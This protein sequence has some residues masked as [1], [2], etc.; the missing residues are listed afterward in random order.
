MQE[1]GVP[2]IF[3]LKVKFTEVFKDKRSYE[4]IIKANTISNSPPLLKKRFWLV[5]AEPGLKLTAFA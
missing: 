2:F 1:W 3:K 5:L 4:T